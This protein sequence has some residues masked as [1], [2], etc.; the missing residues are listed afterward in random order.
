LIPTGVIPITEAGVS[1]ISA[2]HTDSVI[3]PSVFIMEW[4]IPGT[5][6]LHVSIRHIATIPGTH[7]F[8]IPITH[9]FTDI[10]HTTDITPV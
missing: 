6:H 10:H 3:L 8:M 1:I 7:I 5:T 9:R 2:I 4:D